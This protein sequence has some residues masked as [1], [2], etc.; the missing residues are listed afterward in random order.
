MM[1][2]LGLLIEL[3]RLVKLGLLVELVELGLFGEYELLVVHK[4]FCQH[5]AF[6]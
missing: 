3:E 1:G 2:M 4:A 6:S 5:W